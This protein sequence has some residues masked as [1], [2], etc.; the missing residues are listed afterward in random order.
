MNQLLSDFVFT[1]GGDLGWIK[2]VVV[3]ARTG[4]DGHSRAFR[5]AG[6]KIQAAAHIGMAAVHQARHAFLVGGPQFLGH[7]IEILHEVG[8]ALRRCRCT[9]RSQLL[10][11][12][13]VGARG[14]V[15]RVHGRQQRL[16]LRQKIRPQRHVLMKERGAAGQRLR[17]HVA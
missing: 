5:E 13:C 9:R 7:E 3:I 17:R 1:Q 12:C 14:G 10:L 15:A 6:Q 11:R 16:E 8:P 4:D 2:G